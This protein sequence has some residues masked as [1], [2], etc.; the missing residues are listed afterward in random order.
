MQ[1]KR[2]YDSKVKDMDEDDEQNQSLAKKWKAMYDESMALIK[3]EVTFYVHG[4]YYRFSKN[5]LGIF[6]N[7]TQFR[8]FLVWLCTSK[9]FEN[10]IISLILLNSLFLGIKD[11]TDTEQVT[12]INQFVESLEPFFTYIFL[13]EC[14]SKIVAMG[15]L[16]GSNSYLSDAWN[17]LDFTV[18]VTS[19]LNELPSMK[20]MSG[21]RTFRLFRPLRSLTTMPSMKLL[22]GTLLSS[23]S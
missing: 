12:P 7:K 10:T 23:V 16:L 21:L 6:G 1:A 20:N 19:L 15:F 13:F 11:Y 5:S 3:D 14:L 4:R 8:V 17:W 22:I 9:W 18:V 2:N